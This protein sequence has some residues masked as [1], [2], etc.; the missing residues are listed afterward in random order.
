MLSFRKNEPCEP[1]P[2]KA[3]EME[4]T[5]NYSGTADELEAQGKSMVSTKG[6]KQ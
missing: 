2:W 6:D 5:G 1:N 3:K 4:W